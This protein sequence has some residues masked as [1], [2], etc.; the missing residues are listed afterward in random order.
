MLQAMDCVEIRDGHTA[1]G[2]LMKLSRHVGRWRRRFFTL[3]KG[4][5]RLLYKVSKDAPRVKGALSLV[6]MS[7]SC[8]LPAA[9]HMKWTRFCE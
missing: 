8:L 9:G 5:S 2:E 6:G 3:H 4:S 7:V 1:S